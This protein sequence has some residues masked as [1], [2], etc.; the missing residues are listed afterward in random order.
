MKPAIK[1]LIILA[2]LF[3]QTTFAQVDETYYVD[4]QSK[5]SIAIVSIDTK[6]LTLDNLSMGNLMR[7]ELEKLDM[8][9]VLDKYDAAQVMQENEIEPE[10]CFGKKQLVS[11]GKILDA[12]KM[13]TGSA[14]KFGDKIIMILRL[15]DVSENKIEKTSVME[16][17]Y[18]E[19]DIQMMVRLSIRDILGLE[20]DQETLDMLVNL[21]Q[22]ITSDKTTLRLNG[23]RFGMLF[24]NGEIAKR[25]QDPESIGGYGSNPYASIF[26]YQ[27]E[28][29]YVSKGDFQALFEF[30]G[31]VNGIETNYT[32][33]SLVV[34]NGL[35]WQGWEIGFGPAFRFGKFA[36]GYYDE[37]DNWHLVDEN[38]PDDLPYEVFKNIDSRGK[39]ELNTGIIFAAGKTFSVGYLNLP[40]NFYWSPSSRLEANTFGVMLGFNVARHK[41]KK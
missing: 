35:R 4:Q 41:K 10:N 6:G 29:Q 23:P 24:Y 30:I 22:P 1:I 33:F 31:T 25:I 5:P 2:T 40:L 39:T 32:T 14:E 19:E 36:D 27:H 34:L 11:V 38:T 3:C 37:A 16:Y 20:N 9:E 15:I 21:D 18:Q 26:G 17:I 13:L 28:I 8:Y 7:I 12:D